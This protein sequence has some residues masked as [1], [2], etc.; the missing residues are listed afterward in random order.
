MTLEQ[1]L[2]TKSVLISAVIVMVLFG[3]VGACGQEKNQLILKCGRKTPKL[4][5]PSPISCELIPTAPRDATNL[6]HHNIKL[7]LDGVNVASD[8]TKDAAVFVLTGPLDWTDPKHI[9]GSNNDSSTNATSHIEIVVNKGVRITST[10]SI[11]KN[12]EKTYLTS[13]MEYPPKTIGATLLE[14]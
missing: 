13:E 10:P 2:S 9:K 1:K 5:P 6:R 11:K 14:T 8:E 4:T 12:L 7:V 3:G